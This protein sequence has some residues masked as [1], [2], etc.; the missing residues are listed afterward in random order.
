MSG[1]R[2]KTFSYLMSRISLI[3][4]EHAKPKFYIHGIRLSAYV[5]NQTSYKISDTKKKLKKLAISLKRFF[6]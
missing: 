4:Q 1:H 5:L 2:T 3:I 6:Q